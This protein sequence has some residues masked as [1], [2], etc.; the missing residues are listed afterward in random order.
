MEPQRVRERPHPFLLN[1]VDCLG[2]A[3]NGAVM[4]V[5]QEVGPRAV[6]YA[7]RLLGDPATAISLFEEAAASVSEV[8]ESGRGAGRAEVKNLSAYLFRTF[9]RRVTQE[10]RK[11]L[12]L[13][14]SIKE[15][16]EIRVSSQEGCGLEAGVLLDEVMATCGREAREI[17][18]RRLEG[19][20]WK[21]IGAQFGISSHAAELR[22]SKALEQARKTLKVGRWK[23]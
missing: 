2:R 20:S 14:R 9:V 6:P 3:I 5:A 22:F 21:E 10:R 16:E 7:E 11:E 15:G 1:S 8:I 17:A 13:D 19:F 4:S 23:G 18:F 12:A